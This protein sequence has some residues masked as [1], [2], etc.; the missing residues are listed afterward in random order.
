MK[1]LLLVALFLISTVVQTNPII[2]CKDGTHISDL[3]FAQLWQNNTQKLKLSTKHVLVRDR[4]KNT[5]IDKNSKQQTPIA[6]I[7]KL[8]TALVIL[9]SGLPLNTLLTIS[10][11]DIDQLK[12]SS[13]RL[14]VGESF[15]RL[16]L[17]QLA[18]MSSDNRAAH[19]LA[20]TFPQGV[21]GF[22]KAMNFTAQELGLNN[23][24]FVDPTGLSP[25]NLSSANNVADLLHWTDVHPLI[26]Q[27][28]TSQKYTLESNKQRDREYVNTN[29]QLR[30]DKTQYS[31]S[32]TGFINESGHCIATRMLIANQQI[33]IVLLNAD[34]RNHLFNDLSKI[35]R[36]VE[37]SVC[38]Q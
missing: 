29:P 3:P 12:H 11:D 30:Y 20:R 6:S 19:A 1:I 26:R 16:E 22:V 8:M 34:S 38:K 23:T 10:K 15:S 7:T 2:K 5:I 14:K 37:N 31:I 36:S 32:K 35:R 17:L 28:T 13:S 27:L 18:L 9:R 33:D 24:H 25:N 21:E 4:F